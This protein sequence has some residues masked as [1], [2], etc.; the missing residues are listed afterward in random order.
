[1]EIIKNTKDW[2]IEECLHGK[3][4]FF[5]SLSFRGAPLFGVHQQRSM[6]PCI[7]WLNQAW[8]T[9]Y[10]MWP[11]QHQ[12][13]GIGTSLPSHQ[14]LRQ[15]SPLASRPEELPGPPLPGPGWVCN[16]Y[17]VKNRQTCLYEV[18][19]IKCWDEGFPVFMWV[20]RICCYVVKTKRDREIFW[21]HH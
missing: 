6:V 15:Q 2:V 7:L 20:L 9:Y 17:W 11:S 1:M 8:P 5:N 16:C 4:S 18:D 12:R 3:S 10:L 19:G 14:S 21:F 13:Q